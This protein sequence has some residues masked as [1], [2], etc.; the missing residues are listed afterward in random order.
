MRTGGSSL[1]RGSPVRF[2]FRRRR[3]SVPV[4]GAIVSGEEREPSEL[5]RR[6]HR[7]EARPDP[8]WPAP[9]SGACADPADEGDP[10]TAADIPG[11]PAESF[12]LTRKCRTGSSRCLTLRVSRSVRYSRR[13]SAESA[14]SSGSSPAGGPTA[15]APSV[16][17]VEFVRFV[18]GGAN[19][20]SEHVPSQ[21]A[22]GVS[23]SSGGPRAIH[24]AWNSTA[25]GW[26]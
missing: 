19:R 5:C 16:A 2:A 3:I 24:S 18:P 15:A 6:C 20:V 12:V 22:A 7:P 11:I 9:R 8:S 13:R 4:A 23:E 21:A 26:A 1:M 14:S 17:A 25:G 10:L